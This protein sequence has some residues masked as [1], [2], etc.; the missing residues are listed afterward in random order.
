MGRLRR[1]HVGFMHSSEKGRNKLAICP[2]IYHNVGVRELRPRNLSFTVFEL[3][4]SLESIERAL[5]SDL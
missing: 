2:S 4:S 3:L 5:D 1:L